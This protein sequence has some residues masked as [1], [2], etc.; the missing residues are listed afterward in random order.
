M[1]N[2]IIED[3]QKLLQKI[4]AMDNPTVEQDERDKVGLAYYFIEK[5]IIEIK[6]I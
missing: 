5:C 3:L 6:E 1:F 4:E 2:E